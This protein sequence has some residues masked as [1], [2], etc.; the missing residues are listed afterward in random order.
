MAYL[1]D[2]G[3][4]YFWGKI[5][6]WA[7]S[8]FALISHVHPASDVTLM[9]GYSKPSSGSA[10][11][12]SDTL[13]QAVG[14]L[15]AKVDDAL[16]DSDYV[17]KT[18]N[19][20][21]A[22]E[23]KFTDLMRLET[24]SPQI[25]YKDVN[26]T[27]GTAP[28]NTVYKNWIHV[29]DSAGNS[30]T[31]FYG[32][33]SSDSTTTTQIYTYP[34]TN[35]SS[36]DFALFRLGYDSN[37]IKFMSGPSTS[38]NRSN[39]G[40]IVTRDWI[41]R[42]SRIVHIAG[43]ETITGYK[44]IKATAFDTDI[45]KVSGFYLRHP[46]ITRGDSSPAS[47]ANRWLS[48]VFGDAS[49]D[50]EDKTS[51]S[52][53]GRLGLIEIAHETNSQML[54]LSAY[55]PSSNSSH[56]TDQAQLKIGYEYESS[57]NAGI[58][59]G[60]FNGCFRFTRTTDASGTQTKHPAIIVG[61]ETGNHLEIDP[62]EI[63]AKSDGTTP[64]DLYINIDGGTTHVGG[65]LDAGSG[66]KVNSSVSGASATGEL[67]VYA[68]P[69]YDNRGGGKVVLRGS[70]R[71][72]GAGTV[73]LSAYSSSLNKDST[74]TVYPDRGT[75]VSR[76][77]LAPY[78]HVKQVNPYITF[79]ETDVAK[80]VSGGTGWQG[81][82]FADKNSSDFAD[83]WDATH[84]L[85]YIISNSAG[86]TGNYMQF[87]I[88]RPVAGSSDYCAINFAYAGGSTDGSLFFYNTSH[89]NVVKLGSAA[90]RWSVIYAG[91]GSINT[92]DARLKSDISN[93]PDSVLDAWGKVR[94]C[95][96]K[97]NDAVAEKGDKARIHSGAIAQEIASVFESE[98]LDPSRY[99]L[100]CYDKWDKREEQKNASGETVVGE[101]PAG[102]RY[103][104]RYEEAL[105]MEAA[106]QR[107]E[108]AR[109]KERLAA[110][111]ERLAALEM[112]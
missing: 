92:S 31:R 91:T 16:D 81:V 22:G 105:C 68:D 83:E 102:D 97:M 63:M 106:Y 30:I 94:W 56:A 44:T 64:T 88:Y 86:T 19:E 55:R 85:G 101:W 33:I 51:A 18:G 38:E 77:F 43:D 112:K 104:L 69:N 13:N 6:A 107:R 11:A 48:I 21:I 73:L 17:H 61:N 36:D 90:H 57:A 15:E 47:N 108:N 24:Y 1:D 99:A 2:T 20:T 52:G 23:K 67:L 62:N 71:S 29:V 3:L 111:E 25:Y 4:A 65:L 80:G 93:I 50:L 49:G 10:I 34:I 66:I 39:G 40:D 32:V 41:P 53:Y 58:P 87:A 14:K 54:V 72:S 42:D 100:Y 5:K 46:N 95:Q 103:S 78:M 89:D 110:L 109:L 82:R 45:G 75:E 74:L 12:A 60:A 37:A 79:N 59:F 28:Q 7:N 70:Q 98:G 9:T 8:V 96:F 27:R 35:T 26:L 84:A 76:S